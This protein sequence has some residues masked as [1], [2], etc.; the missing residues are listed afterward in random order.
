MSA[1]AG[2][3][4]FRCVI[5]LKVPGIVVLKPLVGIGSRTRTSSLYKVLIPNRDTIFEII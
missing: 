2:M 4:T 5:C 3:L 1:G